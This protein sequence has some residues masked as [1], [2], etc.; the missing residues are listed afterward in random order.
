MIALGWSLNI[1]YLV[2]WIRGVYGLRDEG[3][4]LCYAWDC[5]GCVTS[6]CCLL[7]V[8]L[9]GFVCFLWIVGC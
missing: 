5:S 8:D 2:F 4:N 6:L 1:M 3:V 7:L 9:F